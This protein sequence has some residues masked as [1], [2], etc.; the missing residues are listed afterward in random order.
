M[1]HIQGDAT[2]FVGV[3]WSFAIF[4]ENYMD[5]S[6]AKELDHLVREDLYGLPLRRTDSACHWGGL[7]SSL[8]FA[9]DPVSRIH[10]FRTSKGEEH[11]QPATLAP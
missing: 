6:E 7:T 3:I 2:A 8:A 4:R 1:R 9:I 5:Y 10:F 11:D